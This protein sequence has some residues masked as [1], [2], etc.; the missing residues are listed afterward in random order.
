M[1]GQGKKTM[2]LL[3]MLSITIL[4]WGIFLDPASAK[5]SINSSGRTTSPSI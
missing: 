3:A 1:I 2:T 4:C 5:T